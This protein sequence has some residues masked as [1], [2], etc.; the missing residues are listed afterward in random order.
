MPMSFITWKRVRE[1]QSKSI[2]S[3]P[4]PIP[5]NHLGQGLFVPQTDS[6]PE[7]LILNNEDTFQL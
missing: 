2:L 4:P 6:Y 3:S 1:K 7:Q 5:L